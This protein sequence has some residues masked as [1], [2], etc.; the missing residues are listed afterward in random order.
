[1]LTPRRVED[2]SRIVWQRKQKYLHHLPITFVAVTNWLVV[3]AKQS[4]LFRDN[5]IEL[6]PLAIDTTV[7]RP[8]DRH[9]ARDLLHLPQDKKIV[10]FGAPSLEDPRKGIKYLLEALQKLSLLTEG[11]DSLLNRDEVFLLLAGCKDIGKGSLPFPSRHVGFLNDD[12]TLALA[13]QAAE[14]FVSPSIE[15]AGPMMIP[16]SMLCGA[17]VVAFNTGGAPDL[18]ETMKTG[19]LAAYKDSSDLANGMYALLSS[20]NLLAMRTAAREA[21][22]RRHTPSVVAKQYLDLYRLLVELPDDVNGSLQDP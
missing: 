6:I 22:A 3:R 16:E 12:I 10:F 17:P 7:F 20:S 13:Y 8:F 21:A 2:R 1:Q 9:V 15:D 18:I 4:S 5:R 14:I 11:T 19:Y